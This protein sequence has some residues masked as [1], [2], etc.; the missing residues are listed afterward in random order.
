MTRRYSLMS[1]SRMRSRSRVRLVDGSGATPG[2]TAVK[3]DHKGYSLS[4]AAYRRHQLRTARHFR[5]A[6]GRA[7]PTAIGSA[8]RTAAVSP[9][10]LDGCGYG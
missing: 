3:A 8:A 7:A 10:S 2:E 5:P 6:A 4:W 9:A 1:K